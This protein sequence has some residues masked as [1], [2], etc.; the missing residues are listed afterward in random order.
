VAIIAL[1]VAAIG[2][3]AVI[4]QRSRSGDEPRP[5]AV[6]AQHHLAVVPFKNDGGG[7][8]AQLFGA[9]LAEAVRQAL[10]EYPGVKVA[11]GHFS[12]IAV[13]GGSDLRRVAQAYGANLLLTAIVRR[14]GDD[15]RVTYSLLEPDPD[16]TVAR[17]TIAG[18]VRDLWRI[19]DEIVAGVL[20]DLQI[21]DGPAK[22]RQRGLQTPEEQETYLRAIGSLENAM[23]T[24]SVDV[25]VAALHEL[26]ETAPDSALVHAALG[27]AYYLKYGFTA[28]SKWIERAARVAGRAVQLD[29]E[30]SDA[31]VTF[32]M[33]ETVQGNYRQAVQAFE[34]A[35]VLQPASA[36]AAIGLAQTLTVE[37]RFDE[38]ERMFRRGISLQPRWW[39]GYSQ[40]AT[41]Y[42]QRG[43]FDDALREYQQVVRLHPNVSYGYTGV[44]AVLLA[45]EKLPE[46][47]AMLEKALSFGEDASARINLAYCY[48]YTGEFDKAVESA[49]AALRTRPTRS[50]YWAKLAEA[51][52]ASARH[53][54]E[55]GT[56]WRSAAER[57]R[58]ELET[59]PKYA[60]AHATLALAL[61]HT[62]NIKAASEQIRQAIDLA[63]E[64]PGHFFDAALIANLAGEREETIALLRKAVAGGVPRLQIERHP[65]LRLLR[66]SGALKELYRPG[67]HPVLRPKNERK[68][69]ERL[70]NTFGVRSRLSPSLLRV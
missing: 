40:L 57:A 7:T 38:A 21:A 18:S 43:R 62:G 9:G 2:G 24:S 27:R 45:R 58:A 19:R 39:F 56:A 37:K 61:A 10:S 68:A 60:R 28:D 13:S 54:D 35:L 31:L 6:L 11:D 33:V 66:D 23:D 17:R 26:L 1:A 20:R 16:R 50:A 29:A 12:P 25:A 49:R 47:A 59:N 41:A 64:N 44:G 42:F 46:A 32:G 36:T 34:R 22:Q 55:A 48:F 3:G 65:D 70:W 30:S 69:N 14:S 53:R 63:P 67:P 8:D 5:S 15:L 4:V 51:S 52:A